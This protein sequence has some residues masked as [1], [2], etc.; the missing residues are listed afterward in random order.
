MLP[1]SKKNSQ[2]GGDKK[3]IPKKTKFISRDKKNIFPAMFFFTCF[4]RRPHQLF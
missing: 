2:F 1:I 3:N 4:S